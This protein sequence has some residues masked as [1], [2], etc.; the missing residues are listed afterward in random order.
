MPDSQPRSAGLW[1]NADFVRLWTGE[2]VSEFGSLISAAALPFAAI[3]TLNAAP[4]QM[5]LLRSAGIMAGIITVLFV[6]VWVD[7]L[8]R[9]RILIATDFGRAILLATI[10]IAAVAGVLRMAHLYVVTFAAGLLA[11]FFNVAYR[12][13]LPSIV[14]REELVEANSKLS[15]SS[16]VA[17]VGAFG[18]AG[19][20]VQWLN[21]PFAILIDAVSFVFSALCVMSI[22]SP[23]PAPIPASRREPVMREIA[24]GA[25]FV[26]EH[27]VLRALTIAAAAS[28]FA[29]AVFSTVYMLFVVD[30]LGFKPGVLGMIF[31]VGGLSSL[32]AAMLATRAA[33]RFGAG[34][35]MVAGLI[36]WGA[37]TILVP[38][39]HGATLTAGALLVA[40]Q[41]V[42]DGGATV[43]FINA[44]SLRQTIAPAAIL[45]RVSAS[46]RFI[47]LVSALA[48]SIAGGVVGQLAGLR[49]GLVL[50]ACGPF[51][52]ALALFPTIR[53]L[54]R[55]A[56]ER[57]GA[58]SE[59]FSAQ[60]GS[61]GL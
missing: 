45:G 47:G 26:W 13:Y 44:T 7:R 11:S 17:E 1:R 31:S 48:G 60:E 12:S 10:P 32:G 56:T 30:T 57:A 8:R 46:L 36:L 4:L 61:A 34:P 53:T 9:R 16:S 3:L 41:L 22:R 49:A 59:T 43:Y 50:G 42:G 33:R 20:L 23:E 15:A 25:R 58:A 29:Y 40:H 38:I 28:S 35:S 27:P 39:A 51:A 21:A 37:G 52:A 6:G 24:E 2:T 19:W 55:Q 18:I 14:G 5:A 54:G